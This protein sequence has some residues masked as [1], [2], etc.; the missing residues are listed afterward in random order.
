MKLKTVK[1]AAIITAAAVLLGTA[2]TS[3]GSSN[4][5]TLNVYNWGEY[6]S[7]GSEG[8]FDTVREFEKWYEENYGQKVTVNYTTYASNEDM[9]NKISSGAVSYDVIIPSDYMIEKLIKDDRLAK[10]D[11]SPAAEF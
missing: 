7:D 9:Y 11:V 2:L 6:I 10:I 1:N 4:S 8:S 3:C 5:L